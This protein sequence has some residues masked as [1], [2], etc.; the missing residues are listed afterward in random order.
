M[1]FNR[2]N[3]GNAKIAA[4][5]VSWGAV[6]WIAFWAAPYLYALHDLIHWR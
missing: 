2:T 3:Q 6:L 1:S 4:A 5:F